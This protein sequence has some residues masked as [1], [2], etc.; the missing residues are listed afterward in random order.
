MKEPMYSLKMTPAQYEAWQERRAN[1][2]DA[3]AILSAVKHQRDEQRLA[4][5]RCPNCHE[6]SSSY[7]EGDPCPTCGERQ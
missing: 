3:T 4:S 2:E 6:Y 5:E 7:G 1:V